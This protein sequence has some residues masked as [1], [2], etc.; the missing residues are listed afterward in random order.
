MFFFKKK[1]HHFFLNNFYTYL[2]GITM[3]VKKLVINFFLMI[4]FIIYLLI[5][6]TAYLVLY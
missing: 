2:K 1:R 5:K 6:F 3:N 4:F